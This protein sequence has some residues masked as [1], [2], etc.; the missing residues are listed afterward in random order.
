MPDGGPQPRGRD[1]AATSAEELLRASVE[2][3]NN[4]D[5]EAYG[6]TFSEDTA[7]DEPGTQRRFEG[8][9]ETIGA[10]TGWKSAFSDVQGTIKTLT[11]S[12][13]TAVAEITWRGTHDGEMQTPDGP[14]AP[15]GNQI[16]VPAC[17]VATVEDGE[18]VE[19]R[20]YFNLLTL[21]TQIGAVES[22][23]QE[24]AATN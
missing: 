21:L 1:M 2:A 12:G 5:W 10:A 13:N 11:A 23:T 8:R 19:S 6:A 4:T 9:D 20:H 22:K 16:T 17:I 24:P 3:F 15:T 7:Y 14:I 18:I